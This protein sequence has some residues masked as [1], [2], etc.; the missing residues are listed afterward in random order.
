MKQEED[1]RKPHTLQHEARLPEQETESCE[2]CGVLW[3]WK[4]GTKSTIKQMVGAIRLSLNV[5]HVLGTILTEENY[6][7]ARSQVEEA[8]GSS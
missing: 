6:V 4:K 8:G 5:L 3:R 1:L 7:V 2:S